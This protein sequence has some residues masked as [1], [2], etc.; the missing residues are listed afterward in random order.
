MDIEKVEAINSDGRAGRR[1]L[2]QTSSIKVTT[3]LQAVD[4]ASG[5]GVASA[6]TTE[7][8]NFQLQKQ[9]LPQAQLMEAPTTSD[10]HRVEWTKGFSKQPEHQ[11]LTVKYGG[12]VEFTWPANSRHNVFLLKNQA[13][14]GV[15][16]E[17]KCTFVGSSLLPDGMTTGVRYPV[18]AREEN[19]YFGCAVLAGSQTHCDMGQKLHIKVER[20]PA[21]APASSGSTASTSPASSEQAWKAAPLS[22]GARNRWGSHT[23]AVSLFA[24]GITMLWRGGG[25]SSSLMWLAVVGV[26]GAS[27]LPCAWAQ[28]AQQQTSEATALVA[29]LVDCRVTWSD[30]WTQC[31][32]DGTQSRRYEVD[33]YPTRRGKQCPSG[34]EVRTCSYP[35]PQTI[36]VDGSDGTWGTKDCGRL[37]NVLNAGRRMQ[38]YTGESHENFQMSDLCQYTPIKATVGDV[39]VL[40]KAAPSDDVFAVPSQWHYARCNFSDGGAPLA[41]DPSSSGI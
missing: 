17:D 39:L 40:K 26:A 1:R 15:Y 22:S 30:S 9:A 5:K 36:T 3:V 24:S 23:L 2:L 16:G 33:V 4:A 20:I 41:L 18:S 37:R 7:R 6:L 11:R 35:G 32:P 21:E 13:S 34:P 27:L 28:A 14:F 10:V 31:S 19:L 38:A 25:R 12:V 8:I 29:P